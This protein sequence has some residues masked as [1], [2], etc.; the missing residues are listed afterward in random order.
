M[1]KRL[2]SQKR[3]TILWTMLTVLWIVCFPINPI[4]LTGVIEVESY[5]ALIIAGWVVWAFGMVL[6]MAPI[7]MFPRR[8]GVSE[9]ES[10]VHSNK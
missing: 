5:P 1:G 8:G 3:K 2:L 6:V 9:G 4:V 7:I 10:F